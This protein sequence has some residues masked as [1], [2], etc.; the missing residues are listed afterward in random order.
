MSIESY[1]GSGVLDWSEAYVAAPRYFKREDGTV[2]GAVA[3]NEGIETILPLRPHELYHPDG[4][5]LTGWRI[6]LYSKTKGEI[7]GEVDFFAA[8]QILQEYFIDGNDERVLLKAL[9]LTELDALLRK[10]RIRKS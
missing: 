7:I 8:M 3:I 9:T 10:A 5:T 4:L 1:Q 2:F 6:V